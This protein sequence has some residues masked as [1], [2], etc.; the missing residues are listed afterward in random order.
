MGRGRRRELWVV[1]LRSNLEEPREAAAGRGCEA[2]QDKGFS[3]LAELGSTRTLAMALAPCQV[4]G[5]DTEA[6]FLTA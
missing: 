3:V 4:L 6:K 2:K 1:D 5:I